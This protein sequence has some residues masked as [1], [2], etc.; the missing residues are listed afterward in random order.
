MEKKESD[1]YAKLIK[2]KKEMG[3][4]KKNATNPFFKSTYADLKEI[5]E[6]VEPALLENDLLLIQPIINEKVVTII[7]DGETSIESSKAL[8]EYKNP[9]DAGKEITYYRRYTLQSLLGLSAV[10]DDGNDL[11][12]AP[13]KKPVLKEVPRE[14]E[15]QV[16]EWAKHK[17]LD[18]DELLKYYALTMEQQILYQGYLDK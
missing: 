8:G 13:K 7:T 12:Q 5:L 1:F 10:D 3:A 17:G 9:Q 6:I 15:N 18:V 11:N 2:A 16:F 4:I 14:N